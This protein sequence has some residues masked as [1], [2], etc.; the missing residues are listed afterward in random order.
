MLLGEVCGCAAFEASSALGI[1]LV[2]CKIS[3]TPWSCLHAFLGRKVMQ[4][5]HPDQSV[6][7]QRGF[8]EV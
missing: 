4:Q 6:L 8:V 2:L 3:S 1:A 7:S 5:D